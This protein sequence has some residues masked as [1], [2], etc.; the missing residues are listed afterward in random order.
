M[1]TVKDRDARLQ[2]ERLMVRVKAL[3]DHRDALE[4]RLRTAN[5]RFYRAMRENQGPNEVAA[6]LTDP[7]PMEK[8]PWV[9]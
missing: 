7:L 2:I 3:E 5:G 4:A 8:P 6:V 9:R 1:S